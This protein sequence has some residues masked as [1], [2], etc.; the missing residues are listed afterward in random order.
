MSE[1]VLNDVLQI[2]LE[3]GLLL[4][5]IMQYFLLYRNNYTKT[6]GIHCFRNPQRPA[7][8]QMSSPK[9]SQDSSFIYCLTKVYCNKN[10]SESPKGKLQGT[11]Q[12]TSYKL[13]RG[14][15][16]FRH[17]ESFQP[18]YAT[19]RYLILRLASSSTL[20]CQDRFLRPGTY[21]EWRQKPIH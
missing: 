10:E 21:N 11:I 8:G 1:I 16:Q 12:K 4:W 14:T 20:C 7:P 6:P 19:K 3:R 17:Q 9:D 15:S 18:P 2:C 13:P 5:I